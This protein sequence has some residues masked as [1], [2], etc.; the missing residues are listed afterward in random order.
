MKRF[1]YVLIVL[2]L[3]GC[4]APKMAVKESPSSVKGFRLVEMD[5]G[6]I[7]QISN[8][9]EAP[10]SRMNPWVELDEKSN[11]A[12]NMGVTLLRVV[13]DREIFRTHAVGWLNVERGSELRVTANGKTVTLYAMTDGKRW[14]HNKTDSAGYS[15]TTYYEQIRYQG[16][17][18]AMAQMA[19][20]PITHIVAVGSKGG[21]VWPRNGKTILPEFSSSVAEFYQQQIAPNI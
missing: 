15:S 13:S 1:L 12:G 9:P 8:N 4:G 5:G 2:L 17:P 18:G 20:G 14:H 16:S 11:M 10:L 21:G 3:A 19:S 7:D 6:Y